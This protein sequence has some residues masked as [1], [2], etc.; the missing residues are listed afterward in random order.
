MGHDAQS[1]ITMLEWLIES[2]GHVL[3]S[4]SP[5]PVLAI[6]S[7]ANA[8]STALACLSA[9]V[10]GLLVVNEP[11]EHRPDP[12]HALRNTRPDE[13]TSADSVCQCE[14]FLRIPGTVWLY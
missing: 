2:L 7:S 9:I 8:S 1:S 4:I 3:T 13:G 14:S 11:I 5:N 12:S 6:P 10:A